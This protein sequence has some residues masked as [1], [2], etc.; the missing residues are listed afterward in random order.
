MSIEKKILNRLRKFQKFGTEK[1][2]NG[3][4]LIGKA[5]HIAPLAWLHTI[6][7]GLNEKELENLEKEVG[8]KIPEDYIEFLKFSNGLNIFNTT[9]NLYGLRN[10]FNRQNEIKNRLPFS[11]VDKNNLERPKNAKDKHFFIGSYDW[12]G[13]LLYIDKTN[14]KVYRTESEN[15]NPKNEWTN[16]NDMIL[17]EIYRIIELHNENGTEKDLNEPKTP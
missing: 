1:Q 4:L 17:S 13:S 5:P 6:Y 15:L 10:S 16:F 11:L 2:P 12:D 8:T 3:T 9:F 14:N 7:K